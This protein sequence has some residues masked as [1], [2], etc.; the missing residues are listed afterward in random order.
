MIQ[1]EPVERMFSTGKK[2]ADLMLAG[3]A[4]RNLPEISGKPGEIRCGPPRARA[5]RFFE[6][7]DRKFISGRI[8]KRTRL[9]SDAVRPPRYWTRAE[10][11]EDIP[12][13]GGG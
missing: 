7:S 3:S 8:L 10:H 4:E 12:V 6:Q 9:R 13:R 2:P 5:T 1:D 11:A